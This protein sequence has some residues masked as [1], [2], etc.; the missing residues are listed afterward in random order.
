MDLEVGIIN[1]LFYFLLDNKSLSV[2]SQTSSKQNLKLTYKAKLHLPIID[3]TSNSKKLNSIIAR[4]LDEISEELSLT[5]N[6]CSIIIDD[7]LLYHSIIIRSKKFK[8]INE[9]IKNESEL[10]WGKK[11]KNLYFISE[12]RKIPK[13]IFHSVAIHYFLRDK[14]KL[15][16]NNFGLSIK[17]IIPMSSILT[18]GLKSTQFAVLK[19]GKKF[20]FFGNTRKGFMLFNA[21]F[22]GQ[23]K[24]VEKRIGLL[25]LPTIKKSDLEKNSLKFIHFNRIKIVEYLANYIFNKVPLLNF[26]DS[27][28]A[29]IL[30][31]DLESNDSQYFPSPQRLNHNKFIKNLSSVILSLLFLAIVL[32]FFS[33]YDFLNIDQNQTTKDKKNKVKN[34]SEEIFLINPSDYMIANLLNIKEKF[35]DIDTFYIFEN[36]FIVNGESIDINKDGVS[37]SNKTKI[38]FNDLL[39]RLFEIENN[40]KFKVFSDES[41]APPS[42]NIVL[43]FESIENSFIALSEIN[44]Y[45]NISLIK[46]TFDKSKNS[47]YLYL[48]ILK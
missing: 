11:I 23:K 34:I 26:N 12:E 40:L 41:I 46:A 30:S 32:S 22:S 20:Q 33:N 42:Q 31:G 16:F 10:K 1:W 21:I 18:S 2:Y 29:Q 3:T 8:N 39:I 35:S 44:K 47:L 28:K 36:S 27:N 25:D 17:Y 5:N 45:S 6:R 7:S 4:A 14:I 19:N 38:N 13:N 24:T 43:R 37:F 9:Q 48:T 15:N